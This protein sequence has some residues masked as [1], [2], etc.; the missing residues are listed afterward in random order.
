MKC[1]EG[2]CSS[3]QLRSQSFV[4]DWSKAAALLSRA[5]HKIV[6]SLLVSVIRYSLPFLVSNGH[7][8]ESLSKGVANKGLVKLI[9][10]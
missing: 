1:G 6:Y 10:K 8:L 9:T 4:A 5:G 7:V 2:S 3:L